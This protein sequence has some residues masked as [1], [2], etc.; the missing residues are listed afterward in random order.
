M[1]QAILQYSYLQILDLLTTVVFLASGVE[2]ANPLVAGV[3][4][5]SPSPVIGLLLLKVFAILLGICCWRVNKY[6]L[7]VR[8]N[9]FFAL[10]VAWNLVALAVR[11][12]GVVK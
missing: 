7:L 8:A 6:N 1:N 2:E 10:L 12:A 3:I 4:H 5:L 11:S 9:V